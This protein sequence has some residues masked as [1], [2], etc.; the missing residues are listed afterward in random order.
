MKNL[1]VLSEQEVTDEPISG[2]AVYVRRRSL[3][4]VTPTRMPETRRLCKRIGTAP[5][6]TTRP[7][8]DGD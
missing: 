4:K 5:A 1:L 3:T 6:P 2:L 8:S 7:M